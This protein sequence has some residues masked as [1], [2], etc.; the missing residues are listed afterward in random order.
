VENGLTTKGTKI[1]AK[2]AKL[3]LRT[4]VLRIMKP[5]FQRYDALSVSKAILVF[6]NEKSVWHFIV[7]GT[8]LGFMECGGRGRGA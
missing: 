8:L 7:C 1:F 6:S 3:S 2:N 5:R 4:A